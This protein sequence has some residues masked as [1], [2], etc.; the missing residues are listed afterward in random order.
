[1]LRELRRD[2]TKDPEIRKK[3]QRVL[4][5][6]RPTAVTPDID[7][8]DALNSRLSKEKTELEARINKLEEEKLRSDLDQKYSSQKA[9][10]SNPPYNFDEEDIAEVEKLIKDKE[11]PSYQ[12]A[13]DYYKA[14]NS[15]ARPSGLGIGGTTRSKSVREQRKAFN[16]RYKGLFKRPG[17]GTFQATFDDA[18]EKV[19]TGQ[20]LK[21]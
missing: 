10:L 8:E 1:M 19:R 14:M 7:Q 17:N 5:E 6:A 20:Y 2:L 11:F 3:F 18:Y 15:T 4:K 9:M 13:A 12:V 21:E 16:D